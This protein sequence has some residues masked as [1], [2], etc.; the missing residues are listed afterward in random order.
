MTGPHFDL[1]I[2]GGG[3]H[4]VGVAQAAQARGFRSLL[5]EQ[6]QLAGGTSGRSSKLI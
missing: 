6:S 1:V 2:V 4:G 3:I 5:L